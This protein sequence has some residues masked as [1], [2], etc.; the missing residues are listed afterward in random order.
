MRGAPLKSR[1]AVHDFQQDRT[2][3]NC[4][5]S[6][7]KFD[8]PRMCLAGMDTRHW[9]RYIDSI[10]AINGLSVFEPQACGHL[11]LT[12]LRGI[13]CIYIH[14]TF[15]ALIP[16]L[17]NLYYLTVLIKC[18]PVLVIY[19]VLVRKHNQIQN[20]AVDIFLVLTPELACH[21]R[22]ISRRLMFGFAAAMACKAMFLVLYWYNFG[23]KKYI[24]V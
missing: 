6:T 17:H 10:L 3:S 8:S 11:A 23:T 19:H 13:T 4:S 7:V 16:K 9:F 12:F 24:E 21:L 22:V 15:L 2:L 5:Q 14:V 20:F 1:P 18:L